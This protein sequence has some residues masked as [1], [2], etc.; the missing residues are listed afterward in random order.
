MMNARNCMFNNALNVH[1]PED[2]PER[3]KITGRLSEFR[4]RKLRCVMEGKLS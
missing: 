4:A 1:T 2:I 3:L